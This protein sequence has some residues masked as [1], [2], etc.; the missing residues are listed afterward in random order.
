MDIVISLPDADGKAQEII[1]AVADVEGYNKPNT[2]NQ[3]EAL[4]ERQY[5]DKCLLNYI[6]TRCVTYA[7][8]QAQ[9]SVQAALEEERQSLASIEVS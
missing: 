6:K 9:V 3:P 8:K 5:F 1:K 4:T 7:E 2:F